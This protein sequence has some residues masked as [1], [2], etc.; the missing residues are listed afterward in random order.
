[1]NLRV[2]NG[3]IGV[4]TVV[5]QPPRGRVY[6]IKDSNNKEIGLVFLTF[7][8]EEDEML[9]KKF[10]EELKDTE[11]KIAIIRDENVVF[12]LKNVKNVVILATGFMDYQTCMA[13][14]NKSY[15]MEVYGKDEQEF[16]EYLNKQFDNKKLELKK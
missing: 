7:R 11:K 5:K 15:L 6:G 13:Y 14:D 3:S 16:L 9:A 2:E 10:E 8:K 4:W 1:M 12:A